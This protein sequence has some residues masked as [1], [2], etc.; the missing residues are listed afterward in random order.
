MAAHSGGDMFLLWEPARKHGKLMLPPSPKVVS[1]T[2]SGRKFARLPAGGSRIRT[3]GPSSRRDRLF[4][5]PIE[6]VSRPARA[7]AKATVGLL[8]RIRLPPRRVNKLSV[9]LEMMPVEGSIRRA[10]TDWPS[11]GLARR[12]AHPHYFT[13]DGPQQRGGDPKVSPMPGRVPANQRLGRQD[14]CISLVAEQ[15]HQRRRQGK[16]STASAWRNCKEASPQGFTSNA[17][18]ACNRKPAGLPYP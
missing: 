10:R 5:A 8:V 12:N 14:S 9:P 2:S 11:C 7:T 6:I 15:I 4:A 3:V 13:Y 18:S 1:N 17:A 16:S